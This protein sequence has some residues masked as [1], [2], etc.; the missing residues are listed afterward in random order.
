MGLAG[1]KPPGSGFGTSSKRPT[2]T[3]EASKGGRSPA[4]WKNSTCESWEAPPNTLGT[5]S[6]NGVGRVRSCRAEFG[7]KFPEGV[8]SMLS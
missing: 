5:I 6:P 3:R 1:V 4:T 7:Q 2:Q 8:P